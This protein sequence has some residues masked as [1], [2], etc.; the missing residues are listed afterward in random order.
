MSVNQH[1]LRLYFL[2]KEYT[3]L[4]RLW[5]DTD[6][7]DTLNQACLMESRIFCEVDTIDRELNDL[8]HCTDPLFLHNY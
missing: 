3:R 4:R 1:Q 8:R 6:D 2:C 7:E 5:M